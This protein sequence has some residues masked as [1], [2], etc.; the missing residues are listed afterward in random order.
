PVNPQAHLA[1]EAA[2]AA[3]EQ[4]K[5]WEMHDRLFQHQQAL[6][7]SSLERYAAELGLDQ[8]RFQAALDSRRYR[9]QVNG[10]PLVGAQPIEVFEARVAEAAREAGAL[11]VQRDRVYEELMKA[12]RTSGA[13][14]GE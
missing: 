6:D 3:G 4:G 10:K 2:L 9:E 14:Q 13:A 1:A 5:F 12:A 11:R 7:R 8:G